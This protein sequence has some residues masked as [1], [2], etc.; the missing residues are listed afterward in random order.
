[1]STHARLAPSG[2][3]RWAVCTASTG[4]I[5]ANK[6][7]LP[8]SGSRFADEGTA[9]HGYGKEHL[10]GNPIVM[11]E[12][13]EGPVMSYVNWVNK[14]LGNGPRIIERSVPLFY[15]PKERGTV[16]A[17]QVTSRRIF[18]GDL[19]YGVGVEEVAEKNTQLGIYAESLIQQMEQVM[20][21]DPATPVSLNIWQPRDRNNPEPLRNWTIT[22]KE[23]REFM[24]D[25]I[26]VAVDIIRNRPE[27]AVFKADPEEQ[28]RFCPAKGICKEYALYGIQQT[29]LAVEIF[30]TPI[31]KL[32]ELPNPN[33]MPRDA[34]IKVIQSSK[35]I[36]AWLKEL[37]A[38]EVQELTNGAQPAGMKLVAGRS[39]REWTDPAAAEKLLRNYLA[40]EQVVPPGDIISPAQAEEL[41]KG[42]ETSTRF[43]NRLASLITKPE[44]KPTLVP[45]TDKRPALDLNPTKMLPV[46]G[47]SEEV[48]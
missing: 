21:I 6:D 32:F 47:G 44:G 22:R 14:E 27:D 37:E 4:F 10:T 18:I 19:K 12:S 2:S 48:I 38:Q 1:M 28:C 34:R 30:D 35:A 15:S 3:H 29:P 36:T 5:E 13:F 8:P 33:L 11:P 17:G 20:D 45:E 16:D 26:E 31:E 39:N 23:L 9:A 46:I 40:A 7:K 24:A 42:K 25:T 41:L 43:E